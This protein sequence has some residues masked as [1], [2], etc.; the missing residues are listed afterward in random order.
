MKLEDN[1]VK[2]CDTVKLENRDKI[3]RRIEYKRLPLLYY[4]MNSEANPFSL[5]LGYLW[6]EG[7]KIHEERNG[8]YKLEESNER[9]FRN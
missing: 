4:K 9:Y 1:L 2:D 7:K 3:I 6:V 5:N 8:S